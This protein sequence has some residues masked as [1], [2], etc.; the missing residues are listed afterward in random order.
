MASRLQAELKK[1]R[2]FKRPEEEAFLNVLKTAE[3][4]TGGLFEL[5]KPLGLSPT[6]Y[7]VLRIL[8]GAGSA[9]PCR[10]VGE[11]MVTRE[12]DLTRLLDRMESRGVIERERSAKDRRVVLTSI[13]P[14][15]LKL[16]ATLDSSVDALN[17]RLL[18]HLTPVQ[19]RQL[20]MLLEQARYP[21]E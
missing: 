7:N 9:L 6:Q 1:R 10:D 8:R 2:P 20:S 12:A 14:A 17:G 18:G 21:R 3:T 5:L 15:G 16:L 13:T 11:R 19:L 4:L